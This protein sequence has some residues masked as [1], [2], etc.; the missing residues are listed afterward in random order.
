M[1]QT[2]TEAQ[3]SAKQWS[4]NRSFA[5]LLGSVG[6][7]NQELYKVAI[8]QHVYAMD[9]LARVPLLHVEPNRIYKA[10]SVIYI[11]LINGCEHSC[12]RILK[13]STMI[14]PYKWIQTHIQS[15]QSIQL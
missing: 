1:S 5:I 4:L 8:I 9:A 15:L 14:I 10:F 6:K 7:I 3:N 12:Q 13:E 2:T 11:H